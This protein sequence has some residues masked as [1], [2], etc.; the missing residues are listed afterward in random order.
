MIRFFVKRIEV[1]LDFL[2]FCYNYINCVTCCFRMVL[3]Y[4]NDKQ[5]EKIGL[6]NQFENESKCKKL[7][8]KQHEHKK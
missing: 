5:K 2:F 1:I 3:F 7:Q 4:L 8:P 6:L